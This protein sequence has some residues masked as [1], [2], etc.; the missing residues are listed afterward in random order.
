[1]PTRKT[2][3][4]DVLAKLRAMKPSQRKKAFDRL[5]P[6]MQQAITVPCDGEA[7]TNAHVDNCGLC[8]SAT[9][10]RKLRPRGEIYASV[11]ADGLPKRKRSSGP[12]GP[13]QPEAERTNKKASYRL[14]SEVREAIDAAARRASVT[15]SAM[16]ELAWSIAVASGKIDH[17]I[18]IATKAPNAGAAAAAFFAGDVA[19]AVERRSG[20]RRNVATLRAEVAS[21]KLPIELQASRA[22]AAKLTGVAEADGVLVAAIPKHGEPD[23][24]R[25]F[26]LDVQTRTLHDVQGTWPRGLTASYPGV[27]N[28]IQVPLAVGA[29][30]EVP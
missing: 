1:M 2:S 17:A 3:P 21:L 22:W 12:S 7:H 23:G 13:T 20:S 8:L 24:E 16:V 10:G 11:I 25:F 28:M 27:R 4:A 26:F 29:A 6:A 15:A 19:R 9:W 18:A 5:D 14:R 30:I